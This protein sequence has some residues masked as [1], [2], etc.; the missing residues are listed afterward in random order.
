MT[1]STR[2]CW[3]IT[4]ETNTPYASTGTGGGGGGAS[5]VEPSAA[6]AAV[7]AV[8]SDAVLNG[9]ASPRRQPA[10]SNAVPADERAAH[11]ERLARGPLVQAVRLAVGEPPREARAVLLDAVGS[12]RVLDV[13]RVERRH[14]ERARA[15]RKR[16]VRGRAR[17]EE[18][19]E[20]RQDGRA[21]RHEW[22][23]VGR[24]RSDPWINLSKICQH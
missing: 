8:V 2:V 20:A 7:A 21:R 23:A 5:S 4:S 14:A 6:A 22:A 19:R 16:R 10:P 18:E 3:S 9:G 12:H 17:H 15:R 13:E 11:G 24:S 1:V